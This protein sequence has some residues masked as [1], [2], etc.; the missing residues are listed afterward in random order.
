MDVIISDKDYHKILSGI[1][2]PVIDEET[3]SNILTREQIIEL[4]IEP[5]L[6]TYNLFFPKVK[7]VIIHSGGANSLQSYTTNDGIPEDA[8]AVIG[9]QFVS[10]T[11]STPGQNVL[12]QG[13]FYGNPF[14]SSA[15]VLSKGG[16]FA[17][18]GGRFG[19]PYHYGFK[20]NMYQRN[21]YAK[22]LESSNKVH[23]HN[24]D[25]VTKTL[26]VKSNIAGKF[27]VKFGCPHYDFNTIT[28][29]KQSLLDYCKGMLM[30]QVADILGLIDLELPSNLDSDR[31]ETKGQDLVDGVKEHWRESSSYPSV[32]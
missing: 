29:K 6:A 32:R 17:G 21:F 5:S 9:M 26:V 1:G 11:V 10:Q 18:G 30:L 13:T 22:S 20:E 12:E 7:E 27:V 23:Y 2:Y 28:E 31:L 24:F 19:T 16:G 4:V 8:S 15:Q 3:L 25:P 14:F